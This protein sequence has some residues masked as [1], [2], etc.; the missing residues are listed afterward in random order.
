MRRRKLVS[1]HFLI[2]LKITK[3]R[4][5]HSSCCKKI[6]NSRTR[7]EQNVSLCHRH[8]QFRGQRWH[9]FPRVKAIIS[10][11]LTRKLSCIYILKILITEEL[12]EKGSVNPTEQWKF[13]STTNTMTICDIWIFT[14]LKSGPPDSKW[15]ALS[16]FST[17][18]REKTFIT[19]NK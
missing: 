12:Y 4:S 10:S 11:Q 1:R 5:E 13:K 8:S 6:P 18:K 19:G 2:Y 15:G 14:E 17:G 3:T 16:T 9:P 7:K